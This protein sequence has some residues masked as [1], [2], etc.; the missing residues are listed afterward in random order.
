MSHAQIESF[1]QVCAT[2]AQ[3]TVAAPA[4]APT[5]TGARTAAPAKSTEAAMAAGGD[6]AFVT[7]MGGII[8]L[9]VILL[10]R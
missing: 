3:S 8:V 10:G 9:A 1:A 7:L 6:G 2:C 5:P 4:A